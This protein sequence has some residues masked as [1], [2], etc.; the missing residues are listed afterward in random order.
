M[1]HVTWET[2]PDGD[3]PRGRARDFTLVE[4][5]V[6]I[7]AIAILAAL[8][9]PALNK[10]RDMAKSI[11]CVNNLKTLGQSAMFYVND[12][13]DYL[14]AGSTLYDDRYQR[15]T[16]CLAQY[17]TAG[18]TN[19][20]T[21]CIGYNGYPTVLKF[22]CPAT[23]STPTAIYTYG[24]NYADDAASNKRIPFTYFHP[25]SGRTALQR[26]SAIPPE[27]CMFADA[28]SYVASNPCTNSGRL[29][30]DLSGDGVLDSGPSGSYSSFAP[31]RHRNGLNI[32]FMDGHATWISFADWQTNMNKS[33]IIFNSR[34]GDKL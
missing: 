31:W 30:F 6:T 24:A 34:Y 32:V 33:G 26:F 9:V 27:L 3:K 18:A 16:T 20:Y 4:L 5:L 17:Q 7:A 13:N 12:A 19:G 1:R 21:E 22:Y 28:V 14:P 15:W 8:L 2:T 11:S 10:A 29:T 25:A 23:S